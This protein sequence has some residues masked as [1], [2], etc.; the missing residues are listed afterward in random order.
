MAG[1]YNPPNSG[2]AFRFFICLQNMAVSG[3]FKSSPTIAAGDFKVSKDGGAFANLTTLPSVAPS[4][5]VSVQ[6][7]LSATEMTADNVLVVWIDQTATK[8]WADGSLNI[9]TS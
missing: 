5:S 8:E 6:V 3:S 7:D 2:E 1:A 9:V 4:S